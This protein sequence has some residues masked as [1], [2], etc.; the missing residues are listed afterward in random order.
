MLAAKLISL[1]SALAIALLAG[2]IPAI[3]AG[4]MFHVAQL[5]TARH[6]TH[7]S[8]QQ[9]LGL[10]D[11]LIAAAADAPRVLTEIKLVMVVSGTKA[12]R[13]DAS[14]ERPD[15]DNISNAGGIVVPDRGTVPAL[16]QGALPQDS[17]FAEIAWLGTDGQE[18]F[19]LARNAL[20]AGAWRS[21]IGPA[22]ANAFELEHL[23][24]DGPQLAPNTIVRSPIS[25][26]R[27]GGV[28]VKPVQIVQEVAVGTFTREGLPAGLLTATMSLN[29][30]FDALR[31]K[32]QGD[33]VQLLVTETG[34]RLFDSRLP[35]PNLLLETSPA[36]TLVE[37]DPAIWAAISTIRTG[38]T[39]SPARDVPFVIAALPSEI[40]AANG[41]LWQVAMLAPGQLAAIESGLMWRSVLVAVGVALASFGVVFAMLLGIRRNQMLAMK[42]TTQVERTTTALTHKDEFL[43]RI[44]HDLR[45]PLTAILGMTEILQRGRLGRQEPDR[46]ESIARAGAELERLIEDILDASK[47]ELAEVRL[48]KAPFKLGQVLDKV[49]NTFTPAAEAKRLRLLLECDPSLHSLGLSGD[50]TRLGQV[51]SNL[52]SNAIK[53]TRTG[54]VRLRV[55]QIGRT[56]AK[57]ELEFAVIDTG[58]GIPEHLRD[59]VLTPFER[60]LNA[61]NYE[62]SGSGLGLAIVRHL[63]RLMD[64]DLQLSSEVEQGSTFSF[65]ISLPVTD[66]SDQP[67][68]HRSDEQA[69]RILIAEPNPIEADTVVSMLDALDV[70]SLR[71][72]DLDAARREL[73][74]ARAEG[75]TFSAVFVGEALSGDEGFG[76]LIEAFRAEAPAGTPDR[77]VLLQDSDS[78]QGLVT[79]GNGSRQDV[80]RLT[81]ATDA[82]EVLNLPLAM[83]SL[84]DYLR[85]EGLLNAA[86]AE[87]EAQIRSRTEQALVS[88]LGSEPAPRILFVDDNRQNRDVV[89]QMVNSLGLPIE[90]ASSG[91]EAL[92]KLR[93][94]TFDMVFMDLQMPGMDGRETT[95]RIRERKSR[96]ELPVI[97]LSA[98]LSRRKDVNVRMPEMND[99]LAKPIDFTRLIET[100]LHFWPAR[101]GTESPLPLNGGT[102]RGAASASATSGGDRPGTGASAAT[103]SAGE[104][105]PLV[106]RLRDAPHFDLETSLLMRLGEQGYLNEVAEFLAKYRARI[107]DSATLAAMLTRDKKRLAR[108]LKVEAERIGAVQLR[109]VAQLTEQDLVVDPKTDII[110][111][112]ACLEDTL[113]RLETPSAA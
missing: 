79:R 6:E 89:Q 80:G 95:R 52:V 109:A 26:L 46:L 35:N 58:M 86:V 22:S 68:T 40:G 10:P 39:Q 47:L 66:E 45:T 14:P 78:V 38:S 99:E 106:A 34:E 96:T 18:Y 12:G 103:P 55:T 48:R 110:A 69:A 1:R 30:L 8:L 107:N 41:S 63:L 64:S 43:A 76:A 74:S 7:D 9:H 59:A 73:G 70:E 5:E 71:V 28:L 13:D 23:G 61:E 82:Y 101:G 72:P 98:S 36:P 27:R 104:S 53:Y 60:G 113:A 85:S 42:L 49:I 111:L 19:R 75:R 11:G 93:Q 83:S 20:A 62:T 29:P 37:S 65:R 16:L 112:V 3:P 94:S 84:I 15:A 100:I 24:T 44:S 54:T 67:L 25:A 57:S 105:P 77:W 81:A 97:A 4:W 32:A 90:T 92:E 50:E 102:A 31:A 91:R 88:R 51:V 2:C 21:L 17:Y 33:V 87:H 108:E 56:A